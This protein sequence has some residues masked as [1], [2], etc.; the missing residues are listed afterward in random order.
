[1]LDTT[2][3]LLQRQ[4]YHATGLNQI[5]AES[6]SPKGS[7]YFH[8]P[9]GK[10]QLAAEAIELA[11]RRIVDALHHHSRE[12]ALAS[13]DSYLAWL[14]R[15][16]ERTHFEQGCPIATVALEVG[17]TSALVG[18]AC[19]DAFD[20]LE[21]AVVEW[22]RADGYEEAHARDR[23]VLIYA[24]IEGALVLAKGRRSTEP[25]HRLRAALPQLLGDSAST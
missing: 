1:M 13:L 4:G 10:E 9:G 21:G 25:L 11:G 2:A 15:W 22:L 14:A 17:P 24:A 18:Q 3:T 20:R 5:V 19:A 23:A 8:F 6:G 12:S 16:L 7:M